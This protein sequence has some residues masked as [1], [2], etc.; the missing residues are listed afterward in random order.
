MAN[1]L[2]AIATDCKW[3][4]II[5]GRKLETTKG[6]HPRHCFRKSAQCI[7]KNGVKRNFRMPVCVKSVQAIETIGDKKCW[8][9]AMS[10][11]GAGCEDTRET[12]ERPGKSG[13]ERFEWDQ[14]KHGKG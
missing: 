5:V 8:F 6:A 1:W 14:V 11:E 4:K 2:E 10:V 7:D 3:L 12:G 13:V 9:L